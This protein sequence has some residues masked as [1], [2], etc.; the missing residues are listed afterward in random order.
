MGILSRGLESVKRLW[1]T[2]GGPQRLVLAVAAATLAALLLWGSSAGA[3]SDA[4]QKVV[5]HEVGHA[6]RAEVLKA[7][8][9]KNVAH[10]VRSGGEIW[11]RKAE[12]DRVMLELSG[13]GALSHQAMWK[14]LETSDVFA[15]NWDKD[16]RYQIALQRKLEYMV[17]QVDGVRNASVQISQASEAHRLGFQAPTASASVQV[18]L[19]PSAALSKSNVLAI[20][21]LVANAVPGLSRDRVHLADT[22]GKAYRI[23][24]EGASEI[25]DIEA[26]LEERIKN[27]I[28]DLFENARVVVRAIARAKSE[29]G[30]SVKHGRSVATRE[31]D[32]VSRKK[33]AAPGGLAPSKGAGDLTPEPTP[34]APAPQ[35]EERSS[36]AEFVVDQDRREWTDPAG[37]IERITVG[38]LLPVPVNAEGRPVGKTPPLEEIRKLAVMAS[39]ARPE[40]VS[41]VAL[42]TR[43]PEPIAAVP[44]GER[45]VEWLAANWT[46][47]VLALLCLFAV[48][49]VARAVR[50]ALSKG[51]VEEIRALSARLGEPLEG[52][53]P[54]GALAVG[55]E[56]DIAAVRQTIQEAVNRQPGE[57][58]AA[59]KAWLSGKK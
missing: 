43:A 16:K 5:G 38:I 44:A 12:A 50:A 11:V 56:G 34:A 53:G 10:E 2:L 45:T 14:W 19:K 23:P 54:R 1:G 27:K 25:V 49:V 13:E 18:D 39:G 55:P 31:E 3:G 33:Q 58:A 42:E 8:A 9:Q 26:D 41:V 15:T 51:E 4:W 30:S 36:R 20:V 28:I 37:Q 6:E 52:P 21:G 29:K 32:Q 59:L 46:K 7:L 48:V 35:D 57:A 47:I 22:Q 24:K 17:R 40:D